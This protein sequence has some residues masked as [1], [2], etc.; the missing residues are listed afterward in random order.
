[1]NTA[2]V[3]NDI[4][5]VLSYHYAPLS[6]M[7]V[8]REVNQLRVTSGAERSGR[9]VTPHTSRHREDNACDKWVGV[10]RK[11]RYY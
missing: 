1:M 9:D 7:L 3:G 4:P 10:L 6:V 11:T 5:G 8:H 2:A